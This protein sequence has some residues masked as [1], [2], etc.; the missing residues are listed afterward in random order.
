MAVQA[1]TIKQTALEASTHWQAAGGASG[2]ASGD[3]GAGDDDGKGGSSDENAGNS[4]TE[5]DCIGI[6]AGVSTGLAGMK[7]K[8][9]GSGGKGKQRKV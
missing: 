4:S 5:E 1:I 2:T 3:E 6:G 9:T 8:T 7:R